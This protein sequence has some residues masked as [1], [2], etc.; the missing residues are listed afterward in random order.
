MA[1]RWDAPSANS[2]AKQLIRDAAIRKNS[3]S[4]KGITCTLY[5]PQLSG[6]DTDKKFHKSSGSFETTFNL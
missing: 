2:S 6:T 4:K 1:R 5:N 3:N